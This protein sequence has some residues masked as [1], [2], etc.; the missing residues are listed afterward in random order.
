[1]P[2][3]IRPSHVGNDR[4]SAP[5]P[6]W[7]SDPSSSPQRPD[8]GNGGTSRVYVGIDPGASG[9]IAILTDGTPKLWSMTAMGTLEDQWD[10]FRVL[11]KIKDGD[12]TLDIFVG[13]EKVGGYVGGNPTPGSAMFNFGVGWGTLRAFVVAAGLPFEE[14]PPQRWMKTFGMKADKKETKTAWKNRLKQKAQSLFP[15]EK[16]TLATADALL[17]AEH[18]RRT[19]G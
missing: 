10:F 9:G 19:R 4:P 1:M 6:T 14:I 12:P 15:G 8:R 13:I 18:V 3:P 17:I 2:S 7:S 11:E 16:I 5:V